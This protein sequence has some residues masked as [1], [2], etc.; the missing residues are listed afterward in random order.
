M[1]FYNHKRKEANYKDLWKQQLKDLGMSRAITA[2]TQLHKEQ[3]P[4]HSTTTPYHY[5]FP[6]DAISNTL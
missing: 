3:L 1:Q 2:T 4:I 6:R 5:S